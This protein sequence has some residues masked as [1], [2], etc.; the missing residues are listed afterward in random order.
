M[1]LDV[2]AGALKMY[3][4][5]NKLENFIGIDR[6]SGIFSHQA[7]K[8]M[9]GFLEIKIHPTIQ[10]DMRFL[11]IQDGCADLLIFDPPH[12]QSSRSQSWLARAYGVWSDDERA[13]T[14]KI[15]NKEFDRVLRKRGF[16]LVKI[17]SD[18][19]TLY[20]ILLS[21]FEF[22]LPIYTFRRRGMFHKKQRGALWMLGKKRRKEK[23]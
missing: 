8:N 11:P 21:K 9:W 2:T 19:I 3:A 4:G 5:W 14:L 1:I 7:T 15:V 22:F 13:H 16:I 12:V 10:A 6:R 23:G 20:K 17:L 18:Q